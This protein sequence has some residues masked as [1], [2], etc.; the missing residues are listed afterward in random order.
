MLA[1]AAVA[2]EVVV[3]ALSVSSV[4]LAVASV[5]S[6]AI[7]A[8]FS[9]CVSSVANVCPAVT[10]SPIWTETEETEPEVGNPTD[11]C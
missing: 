4:A 11:F 1:V 5:A 10:F 3:D 2:V 7:T 8:S 6:A 9:G